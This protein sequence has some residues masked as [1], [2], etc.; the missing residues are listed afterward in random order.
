ML[1][2]DHTEG[3]HLGQQ[4]KDQDRGQREIYHQPQKEDQSQ[5]LKR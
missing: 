4:I 5:R 3:Q 1:E 2:K